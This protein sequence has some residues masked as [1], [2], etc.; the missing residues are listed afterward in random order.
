[1]AGSTQAAEPTTEGGPDWL[2]SQRTTELVATVLLSV[3]VLLTA[4]SAWQ[5]T[6]W[7]GVQAV[8]FTEAGGAT[9]Q[10]V[11]ELNVASAQVAYDATT[12]SSFSLRYPNGLGDPAT[13]EEA[14]RL[15]DRLI[16][17]EFRP[18]LDAWLA[19]EPAVN[20]EA[21]R[22]PFEMEEYSNQRQ[23]EAFRLQAFAEERVEDGKAANQTGDDYVLATVFLAS[24]LFFGGVS[25]KIDSPSLRGV[26][27]GLA[28][29]S[30][31]IGVI[32]ILSLPFH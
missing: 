1:M 12:F 22:T 9:T 31:L 26:V 27:L 21:P 30:L 17:P 24:T 23:Q 29:M 13:R 3:A 11:A 10:S 16:R 28:G 18:A 15:A 5:A 4:F 19:L 25:T 6:R 7:S 32:R 14:L 8:A 2:L 20:P